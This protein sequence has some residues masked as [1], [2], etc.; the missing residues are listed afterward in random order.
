MQV[1]NNAIRYKDS[2]KEKKDDFSFPSLQSYSV[3]DE[4]RQEIKRRQS[5]NRSFLFS[6]FNLFTSQ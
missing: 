4:T 3:N 2:E 5:A 6:S 1:F